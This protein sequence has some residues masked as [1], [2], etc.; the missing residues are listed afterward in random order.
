M[1]TTEG[2][3]ELAIEL[4]RENKA[5][6]KHRLG[7]IKDLYEIIEAT[8]TGITHLTAIYYP[9]EL[10]KQTSKNYLVK[11]QRTILNIK[12]TNPK[13]ITREIIFDAG[14]IQQV[15]IGSRIRAHINLE[16]VVEK[17]DRKFY[18]KRP[19]GEWAYPHQIEI[20]QGDE[21]VITYKFDRD[22]TRDE[23]EIRI[24]E[25]PS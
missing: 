2:L 6:Q 16:Y 18:A 14:W 9:Q 11:G 22:E 3:N 19:L 13:Q 23:E 17:D 7:K 12:P 21:L 25:M 20:M 8:V 4:E 5:I 24:F 15:Q 1:G 10:K